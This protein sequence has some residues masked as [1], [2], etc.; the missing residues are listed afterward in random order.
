MKE[1]IVK[2]LEIN[3]LTH[4]VKRFIV[5]KPEGYSYEGGDHVVMSINSEGWEKKK[6]AFSFASSPK[7]DFLEFMIKI[8]SERED[9]VTKKLNELGVGDELIIGDA[10]GKIRYKGRGVFIAAG[11]GITPF[12]SLFK[13]MNKEDFENSHL[14][15]SNQKQEDIILKKELSEK[16]GESLTLVLSREKVNEFKEGRIDKEFL[17]DHVDN[18]DQNFY[19]CGPF[20]M[21]KELKEVLLG[22]GAEESKI[23]SEV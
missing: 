10:F 17:K 3:E 21:V 13:N 18:F 4:N 19:I 12:I 11:S 7:E 8:Y 5:S 14:I 2:I 20:P 22:L 23:I 15:Y 9:G 16:F 1:Y 6:R